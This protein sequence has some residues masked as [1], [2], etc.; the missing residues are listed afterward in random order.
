MRRLLALILLCLALPGVAAPLPGKVS[1][2]EGVTEYRL[3]NGLRLLTVPDPSADTVTVHVTYLV[4]SRHEGYGEKGMAHL[5][6]HMLF[7]GTQRNPRIKEELT[8]RG[9]RYNG[10]TSWDR[11]NYFETLSASEENLDWALG[12]EADRM[13]NSRVSREDLD[14]EMTVVRN[15]FE[16]GENR[17]G[18]VLFERTMQLAFPW[19]ADPNGSATDVERIAA[20][21]ARLRH[22][23]DVLV[24]RPGVDPGRIAVVGHDFGAMHAMLLGSM[25]RRPGAYVLIAAVPRRGDW[26]LPFWQ[27]EEDRIDYLRALRPLDPIEHVGKLR[28]A[29]ILLQFALRD[30][31]IA[32]MVSFE[33][34]RAADGGAEVKS[35]EAEHDMASPEALADRTAFLEEALVLD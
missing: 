2:I 8:R 32:P 16:M 29:R 10:S 27:I 17:A 26:F 28:P 19:H 1:S 23:L 14:S 3:A 9:A 20:E 12:M 30:F 4:G 33:F 22:C 11:T 21:V 35:Y 31:Y 24:A 34:R 7:K 6:E 18:S 15:E 25:D 13:V 5:L